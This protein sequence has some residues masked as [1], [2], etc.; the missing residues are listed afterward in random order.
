MVFKTV[1]FPRNVLL[2]DRN[3]LFRAR[4]GTERLAVQSQL[5]SCLTSCNRSLPQLALG[6]VFLPLP[7]SVTFYM[8]PHKLPPPDSGGWWEFSVGFVCLHVAAVF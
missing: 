6:E 3:H 5:A 8:P 2:Q 7:C 4:A 1:R